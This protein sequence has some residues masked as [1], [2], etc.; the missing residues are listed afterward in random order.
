MLIAEKKKEKNIAEYIIYIWQT[1]DLIRAYNFDIE[2]IESSIISFLPINDAEKTKTSLWY[3][4]LIERMRSE[5]LHKKGHLQLTRDIMTELEH[6]HQTLLTVIHDTEYQQVYEKARDDIKV[7]QSIAQDHV[8]N[9]VDVCMNGLYGLLLLRLEN[10]PV[11]PD[12]L[13]TIE[14]FGSV[15]SYLALKYKEKQTGIWN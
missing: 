2:T 8:F 13:S 4:D 9:E 3:K 10:K 14:N 6:I 15:M 11:P 5:G 12:L 1:E 7:F